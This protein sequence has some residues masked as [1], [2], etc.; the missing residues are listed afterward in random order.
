MKK[1]VPFVLLFFSALI[2][3]GQTDQLRINGYLSVDY[4]DGQNES[5]YPFGALQNPKLGL[6]FSGFLAA[7][8]DYVA[9]VVLRQDDRVDLNQILLGFSI[10]DAFNFNLGLYLV[11]FG[12]YNE[13]SR[14]HQTFLVEPPM[15]VKYFYPNMWRDIGIQV[16]GT[17]AGLLYSAYVG[18]GLAENGWLS[19]GQQFKD[20]NRDKGFGGRVAWNIDQK[21]EAGYSY[22]RGRYDDNNSRY[23][24]L[25]NFDLSFVSQNYQLM[26]E[27]VRADTENPTGYE[28]G[29]GNGYFALLTFNIQGIWPVASYQHYEFRDTFHGEGFYNLVLP[30]FGIDEERERWTLGLVYVLSQSAFFKLEYQFN[31]E[32]GIAKKNDMLL[33]QVAVSF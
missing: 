27:Y 17:I 32:T 14:A 19:E 23:L 15:N 29:S 25:Q 16:S 31:R 6:I 1:L 30:G 24:V 8:V 20:N 3:S 18:N 13:N 21:F 28:D 7:K 33:L 10:S 12:R 2:L 9:E 26:G 4:L 22:Y 5:D 11:P